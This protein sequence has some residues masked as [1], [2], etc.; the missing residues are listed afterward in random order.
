MADVFI[1]YLCKGIDF[2][3]RVLQE[4]GTRDREPWVDW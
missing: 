1:S 3:Q 4:L 2:T